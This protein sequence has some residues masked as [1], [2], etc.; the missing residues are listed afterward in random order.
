MQQG[1]AGD[2]KSGGKEK[3]LGGEGEERKLER[4]GRLA[5]CPNRIGGGEQ[6]RYS[7][8]AYPGCHSMRHTYLTNPTF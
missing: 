1:E 5:Y 7:R 8:L 4:T 2:N 3:G 6:L